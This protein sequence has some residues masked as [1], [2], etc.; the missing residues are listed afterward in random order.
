VI[1]AVLTVFFKEL[2]DALRDRRTLLAMG[3]SAVA[4]GPLV[5]VLISLLVSQLETRA[6]RRVLLVAGAEHAPELVNYL[7]RQ[8]YTLETPPADYAAR[9]KS[10]A[11][12]D[13]VLV[14]PAD[15]G[16]KRARAEAP[17]VEIVSDSANQQADAQTGRIGALL[18][19]FNQEQGT[20]ALAL[21]G[22]APMVLKPLQVEHRDLASVQ[23]RASRLTGML[24]F[25]VLMA[26][27][28]GA[29][30]AALD[31]SA[32]ERERGSLEPLLMNPTARLH[33]VLGKWLAVAGVG[34]LVALLS[35]LS[36]IPA[37][38]LIRS[39]SLQALFIY[40]PR[41]ALAF[42]ATLLPFAAALSALLMAVAMRSKTFKEA[43]ASTTFVILGVSLLP[44]VTLMGQGSEAR[45]QLWV[46]ALAQ[47]F[48]M[49]RVLRGE[50][51]GAAE[52]LI[53]LVACGAL[54]LACLA[55]VT[56]ML[57]RAKLLG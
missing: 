51:L 15:Y 1:H 7:Q 49:N 31:T 14:I 46:P 9:L 13:P 36:F 18:A 22:V 38:W 19:G 17:G 32:G 37:Q 8:S 25:F 48:V 53:P 35:A 16:A 43:Q 23:A 26:V 34:M 29:L 10:G 11:L 44:L 28:Y 27:L 42:V 57:K 45:W 5:L 52:V 12:K 41:E 24:P 2:L 56:W 33:L 39:D 3:V 6:E 54:T 47:S 4:I 40:G 50:P 21:R 20:L 55:S 30:N